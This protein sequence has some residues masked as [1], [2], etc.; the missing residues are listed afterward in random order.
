MYVVDTSVVVKWFNQ[1]DE[2]EV[3]KSRKIYNELISNKSTI[4]VPDLLTIELL[5]VLI[6]SK[7]L[8]SLDIKEIIKNLLSLPLIIKQPTLKVLELT[9]DI[10][11][12]YKIAAYD[13]LFVATAQTENCQLISNDTKGH[14]KITD[15]TVIMI[16]NY[17]PKR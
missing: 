13:A 10:A 7:A 5:N 16:E 1:K 17:N 2:L 4:I 12:Y 15:G 9:T 11:N 8:S 3:E 6:K 14:G